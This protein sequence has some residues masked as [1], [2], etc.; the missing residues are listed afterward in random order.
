MEREGAQEGT[1]T[2]KDTNTVRE[3]KNE[4]IKEEIQRD[5]GEHMREKLASKRGRKL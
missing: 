1:S 5:I 3:E 4:L 2:S